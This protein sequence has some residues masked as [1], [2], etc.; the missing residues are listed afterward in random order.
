MSGL[1]DTKHARELNERSRRQTTGWLAQKDSGVRIQESASTTLPPNSAFNYIHNQRLLNEDEVKDQVVHNRPLHTVTV[2]PGDSWVISGND[3]NAYVP[4]FD[5]VSGLACQFEDVPGGLFVPEGIV[6]EGGYA[7]LHESGLD[8]VPH[9]SHGEKDGFVL[10]VEPRYVDLRVYKGDEVAA[11]LPREEW[12]VDPFTDSRFDFDME[13]FFVNRMNFDLYGAGDVDTEWMIR[14]KEGE[15]KLVEIGHLGVPDEPVLDAYNQPVSHRVESDVDVA[16]TIEFSTGPL[17]F[18]TRAQDG[19]PG[20][21]KH[22]SYREITVP[23]ST[24]S[25]PATVVTVFR[26]DPDKVQGVAA[27]KRL[28]AFAEGNGLNV[29]VR[30]VHRDFLTWP[31]GFD[32]DDP[33]NWKA[34]GESHVTE[35]SV[36]E[37]KVAPGDVTLDTFVDSDDVEKLRGD[38]EGVVQTPDTGGSAESEGQSN[39]RSPISELLYLALVARVTDTN[40]IVNIIEVDFEQRW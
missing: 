39:D 32:P 26:M 11:K 15:A 10:H 14:T 37:A 17:H 34:A 3:L 16:E 9:A 19:V 18:F 36:E 22:A 23:D 38:R 7:V 4:G 8:G 27:V 24:D 12:V 20:R 1:D 33:T 29:Q 30:S 13:T 5:A 28:S 6:Y 31:A 21:T 2:A 35:T 25:A 40:K